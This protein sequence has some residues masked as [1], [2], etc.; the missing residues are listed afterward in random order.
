MR[1]S[2]R[3]FLGFLCLASLSI[4]IKAQDFE[5][6]PVLVKFDANPGEIQT[7]TL[8]L[9]NHSPQRQKYTFNLTD[10]ELDI[11]GRKKRLEPGTSQHSLFN[12]ININPAFVELNPNE[13]AE[14]ELIMS[15]PRN[16]Y[17]TRWGMVN[18][19]V[20]KEQNP[21]DADKQLATGVIIVPRI[22]VLVKQ[23]PRANQNYKAKIN[24]LKEITKPGKPFRTFEATIS[25]EGDK[26]VDAHVFLALA[27]LETAEEEQFKKT[28]FSIYPGFKRKVQLTLPVN[29]PSGSYALAM[30][31][32]YG[33][34]SAIEGVQM[35][36][37]VK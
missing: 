7:R 34:N 24:G 29:P 37:E 23:S 35:L 16:G 25:N 30:L 19:E 10:Y 5:V 28:R 32:D 4:D 12:W 3:L 15:V 21:S 11:E 31:M 27:N 36:M 6:A 13:S 17:S 8:T 9:R 1:M 14:I 20:S 2:N 26:V 33:N 22:V 18:V